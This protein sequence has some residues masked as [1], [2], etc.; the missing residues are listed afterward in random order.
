[1]SP[2]LNDPCAVSFNLSNASP[3]LFRKI[4]KVKIYDMKKHIEPII[5]CISCLKNPIILFIKVFLLQIYN[6]K[7]K[8]PNIFLKYQK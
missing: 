5:N 2:K 7:K 6:K 3:I 8:L 1:M 4:I